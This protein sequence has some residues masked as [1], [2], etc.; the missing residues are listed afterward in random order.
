VIEIAAAHHERHDG[1]GYP[2]GLSG[3][4]IPLGARIA[5]LVDSYDAMTTP[6]PYAP[7]RSSFGAMQELARAKGTSFQAELVEQMMQA[8]G[9]FPTGSLVELDTGEV[10]IVV[11][12][13]ASRRLKPKVCIVLDHEKE[14]RADFPIV[15]LLEAET[16]GGTAPRIARELPPGAYGIDAQD[17][18][19]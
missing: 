12:Q 4:E 9:L 8:I 3:N 5:G 13:N 17:Y 16:A 6:R 11:G 10:A 18:Y 14:R 1:S 15:D 19:L 7:P 2:R